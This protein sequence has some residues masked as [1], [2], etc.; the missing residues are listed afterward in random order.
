MADD[1]SKLAFE[2]D[3]KE[4]LETEDAKARAWVIEHVDD[5]QL[6]ATQSPVSAP[7]EKY[8][9][10]LLW[11]VYPINPP[12]LKFR[13]PASGRLD[14]KSAWPIVHGYRPDNF[15]ACVNWTAEGFITHPEWKNDANLRW[16]STGNAVL[17][18]LRL[19]QR[20]LDERHKGRAPA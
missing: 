11:D 1:F 16:N 18:V 13:D 14:L 7:T 4:A 12:S 17:R 20:D 15:D 9:A 8:Q 10:R 5:L 2:A 19:I 6:Y 3:L